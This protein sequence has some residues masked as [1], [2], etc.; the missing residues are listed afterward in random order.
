MKK[1]F[2]KI[3]SFLHKLFTNDTHPYHLKII[4]NS[5]HCLREVQ[6]IFPTLTSEGILLIIYLINLGMR[7]TTS[8][9]HKKINN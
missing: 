4:T 7:E 8:I 1:F 2:H 9:C 3:V 6:F 5:K